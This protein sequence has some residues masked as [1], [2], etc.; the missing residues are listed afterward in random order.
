VKVS[1][2]IDTQREDGENREERE[3]RRERE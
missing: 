2:E 1:I 3:E